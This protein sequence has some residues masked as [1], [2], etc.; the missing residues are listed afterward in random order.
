MSAVVMGVKVEAVNGKVLA[1]SLGKLKLP[2]SGTIEAKIKRLV[3]HYKKGEDPAF[4]CDTCDGFSG[5]EFELCPYCGQDDEVEETASE[6]GEDPVEVT[7]A[8]VKANKSKT[9]VAKPKTEKQGALEL[10]R[11]VDKINR[12]NLSSLQN[13]W[14]VGN[15]LGMIH[16]SN[17]WRARVDDEGS[18]CYRTFKDF[19]EVEV[20]LRK[21][22]AY[23]FIRVAKAFT[24]EEVEQYGSKRLSLSLKLP[25]SERKR[26]LSESGALSVRQIRE[27]ANKLTDRAKKKKKK[28]GPEPKPKEER[29]TLAITPGERET[30]PLMARVTGNK[31][32][33]KARLLKDGPHCDWQLSNDIKLM[34][35]VVKGRDGTLSLSIEKRRIAS[36]E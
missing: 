20:G 11:R 1:A 21:T 17:M 3:A 31:P 2:K 4:H 14:Q 32:P 6:G 28:A 19:C 8:I 23:E 12:L 18:P 10:T 25:E 5:E 34:F 26:L 13:S 29:L 33:R 36:D 9:E 22:G 30:I 15:E 35:R 16:D 27:E 24:A 7:A